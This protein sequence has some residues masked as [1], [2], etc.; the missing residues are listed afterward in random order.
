MVIGAV[1]L[2]KWNQSF[3]EHFRLLASY[4]GSW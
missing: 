3:E 1:D 4:S 2:E